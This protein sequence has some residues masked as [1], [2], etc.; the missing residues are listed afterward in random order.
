MSAAQSWLSTHPFSFS[1]IPSSPPSLK[2]N[3]PNHR[4]LINTYQVYQKKTYNPKKIIPLEAGAFPKF[5]SATNILSIPSDIYYSTKDL[6]CSIKNYD[7]EGLQDAI[8]SLLAVP[9]NFVSSIGTLLNYG[10]SLHWVP[11]SVSI[12]LTPTY[13]FGIIL[14]VI[15]GIIDSFGLSRQLKFSKEFDFGLF[16]HLKTAIDNP[17][18]L[19]E[20]KALHGIVSWIQK[21]QKQCEVLHGKDTAEQ[22]L[23]FFTNLRKK[24]QEEPNDQACISETH[25]KKIQTLARLILT[26]NL[27]HLQEQYLQLDSKEV[28]KITEDT[29][30]KYGGKTIEQQKEKLCK[31]L[32]QSLHKKY[33]MLARRVRPWMVHEAAETTHS[34]LMGLT[35]RNEN[36]QKLAIQEGLNLMYDMHVQNEKKKLVH[37]IGIT[38]LI[39]ATT[40]LIALLAGAPYIIPIILVTVASII[41]VARFLAFSGSLDIRGWHFS[42]KNTL[43]NWI[44]RKIWN[45]NSL[46]NPEMLRRRILTPLTQIYASPNSP[47]LR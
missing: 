16:K 39:I 38:C 4:L 3:C 45:R 33:K 41:G 22:M 34:I 10:L 27:L 1:R 12:L 30:K 17:N 44:Q 32:D 18:I 14:C 5:P 9:V 11:Q 23:H 29:I 8:T 13:I 19:K 6:I 36:H 2:K 7:K 40:S 35:S 28:E 24:L 15:E 42:F 43:P 47:A 26:N 20:S 25:Q 31:Y 21:N 37:T 46:N